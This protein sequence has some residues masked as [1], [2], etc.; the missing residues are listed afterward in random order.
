MKRLNQVRKLPATPIWRWNQEPEWQRA[1]G[2]LEAW[3]F[4]SR[5]RQRIEGRRQESWQM[6]FI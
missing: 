3:G 2:L 1:L 5:C 4:R 6:Q